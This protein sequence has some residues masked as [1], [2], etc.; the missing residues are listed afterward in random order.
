MNVKQDK[1][2]KTNLF[3][4][5]HSIFTAYA[6]SFTWNS[7]KFS[8]LYVICTINFRLQAICARNY[9]GEYRN[10]PNYCEMQYENCNTWR[11]EYFFSFRL[12]HC[13]IETQQNCNIWIPTFLSEYLY[14]LSRYN[15]SFYAHYLD[16]WKFTIVPTCLSEYLYMLLR[17]NSRFHTQCLHVGKFRT[18]RSLD[19]FCVA[20]FI[21]G[22]NYQWRVFRTDMTWEPSRK[23]LTH[24]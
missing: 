7:S 12:K 20:L 19:T 4:S 18:V 16:V 15:S 2:S 14:I 5:W 10:F 21:W 1:E 6:S 17:Q 8:V 22:I 24:L 13:N 3:E 23:Q 9:N 11:S